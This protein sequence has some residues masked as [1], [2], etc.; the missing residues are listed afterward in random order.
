[1]SR[2][3]EATSSALALWLPAIALTVFQLVL[4]LLVTGGKPERMVAWDAAWYA[5]IARDGYQVSFPLTGGAG[6]GSN[7]AFFPGFPAW[8]RAVMELTGLSARVAVGLAAQL[9]CIGLW[10][11]FL[12]L[13]RKLRVSAALSLAATVAFATQPGAFYLIVGY[14]ESL[15]AFGILGFIWW[16]WRL[17]EGKKFSFFFFALAAIHGGI[18]T[19]T[20][21]LGAA[22]A[23]LPLLWIAAET[24]GGRR[25]RAP[26]ALTALALGISALS[27]FFGYLLYCH[28]RFGLWNVYWEANRIGWGVQV[29]TH[30]LFRLS[31]YTDQFF[32]GNLSEIVGRLVT[33]ATLVFVV[34]GL[35]WAWKL[36]AREPAFLAIGL[37]AFGLL[38]ETMIGSHGMHSMVRYLV[39]IQAI[40]IPWLAVRAS[41]S[42]AYEKGL[43]ITRVAG[44]TAFFALG[45]ALQ[46]LFSIRYS[47][48]QW[49]S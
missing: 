28:L 39:P 8:A 26:R 13:L 47:L 9:A 10:V 42:F 21:F 43:Q 20:R 36:R 34:R 24:L 40:V 27:G 6:G 11:Y 19:G 15:F 2:R 14:A 31:Y 48:G 16:T 37:L 32:V 33:V 29:E 1:M 35:H 44:W 38:A 5:D 12:A 45:L 49:V 22:L 25:L 17:M 4:F 46:V 41:E 30:T 3:K 7:T 18:M 23:G